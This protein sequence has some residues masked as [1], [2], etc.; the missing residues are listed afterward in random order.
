MSTYNPTHQCSCFRSV[1]VFSTPL[2][3]VQLYTC[4]DTF[5]LS[6][7]PIRAFGSLM[8]RFLCLLFWTQILCQISGVPLVPEAVVDIIGARIAVIVSLLLLYTRWTSQ[9]WS[10]IRYFCTTLPFVPYFWISCC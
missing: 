3:L 1:L 7:I 9:E 4:G 2:L 6:G 8:V 10:V 5:S